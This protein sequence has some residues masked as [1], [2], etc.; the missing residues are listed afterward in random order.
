MKQTVQKIIYGSGESV[1]V[2]GVTVIGLYLLF[3][4]TDIVG[5]SP[6]IAGTI[7]MIGRAWDAI[8]DP[9]IGIISDKTST[10]W[11]RR[12]PYF[13]LATLPLLIAFAFLW[14]P[15]QTDAQVITFLYYTLF[16]ILFMTSLTVYHVPYVS[17]I[18]EFS[19][20]YHERTSINNYR[21][22]FQLL[23]GLVAATI[24][25]MIADHSSYSQMAIYVGI[26]M[27]VISFLVFR[28]TSEQPIQ[29]RQQ[30][31][32]LK[33]ELSIL[34]KNRGLKYLLWIYVGCY[35]AANIIE[36]FVIYYM[37]YWLNREIDMPIL[38][39]IV[40]GIGIISL[41]FW[42]MVSNKFGKRSA[43]LWG[44]VIWAL[45]QVAWLIVAPSSP[46][47]VVYIVGAVVGIGYGVAHVLPWAMLPDVVD[48]DEKETGRKR[49]GLYAGVMTF[50]M[51]MTN[52]IAIFLIGLI[53][54]FSGY[55]ANVTQSVSTLT[56]IK[57]TMT[58]A[59]GIFV[60][61]AIIATFLYPFS[62]EYH[63]NVRAQIENKNNLPM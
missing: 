17:L 32:T 52:S 11:G 6:A 27:M 24:P 55:I 50:F 3:F 31:F 39:V 46:V 5:L 43:L 40:I 49:E 44:L 23:V 48:M 54:E 20:D 7:F 35:A 9:I 60:V 21:I 57:W 56:T 51:K 16:Y 36:G 4:L 14:H 45:G 8:S 41:P 47:Y 58:I 1:S 22:F 61:I 10:R 13:L 62:R 18:T 26:F 2:M 59:P 28:F 12:R 30:K 29:N 33:N 63:L 19:S 37:K 38:F 42:S 53:L 25:K 15:I 34:F